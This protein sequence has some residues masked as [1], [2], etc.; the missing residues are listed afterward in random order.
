LG[1]TLFFQS[2]GAVGFGYGRA[3]ITVPAHDPSLAQ[4]TAAG[5]EDLRL[6][7]TRRIQAALPGSIGG[8]ASG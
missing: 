3:H 6:G 7:M 1:R 8:I 5:V 4:R 2:I